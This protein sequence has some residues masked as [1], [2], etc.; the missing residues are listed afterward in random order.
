MVT[1]VGVGDRLVLVVYNLWALAAYLDCIGVCFQCIGSVLA[2]F[3]S[4]AVETP[5]VQNDWDE[6][7]AVCRD[8]CKKVLTNSS[9]Q[10]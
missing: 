2:S 5:L 3:L 7:R 9:S 8:E 1:V 6:T 4:L 10:E